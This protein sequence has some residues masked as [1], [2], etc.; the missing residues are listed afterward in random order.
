MSSQVSGLKSRLGVVDGHIS[1]LFG[2]GISDIIVPSIAELSSHPGSEIN[3]ASV[4]FPFTAPRMDGADVGGA[5]HVIT[6]QF[7][8]LLKHAQ[9]VP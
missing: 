2:S 3:G 4:G 1:S 6:A 9:L 5:S 8:S 7:S